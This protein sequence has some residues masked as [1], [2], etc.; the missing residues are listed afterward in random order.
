MTI[1]DWALNELNQYEIEEIKTFKFYQKFLEETNSS[2]QYPSYLRYLRKLKGK[3]LNNNSVKTLQESGI[4]ISRT[5]Q[6]P[7]Y[8]IVSS[9]SK[10][11]TLD[12]LLRFCKVDLTKYKVTRH[13]VNSWGKEGNENFQVK[14]WLTEINP[15]ELT[16]EQQA[17][18]FKERVKDFK[19]DYSKI[20]V[21]RSERGERM[22]EISLFDFHLGQLSWKAEVGIN[23]DI[24]IAKKMWMDATQ[25]FA[26]K[27]K[28][29]KVGE[30]LFPIGNDFF[31]V[32][33]IGN[34]TTAGTHQDEDGRV[35]KSF[36][37]GHELICDAI[38]LLLRTGAKIH[39]LIVPGNHDTQ[40]TFYLGEVIRTYYKDCKKVTVD[41]SPASRKYCVYGKNLI[42]FAHGKD[43]KIADLPNLFSLEAAKDW[44]LV[45]YREIHIGHYHHDRRMSSQ[46]V[47]DKSIRVRVMPS[48]VPP[49]S[50]SK[51]KGFI[52]VREAIGLLWKKEG[53]RELELYYSPKDYEN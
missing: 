27:V 23:Y 53:G 13:V 3:L 4:E 43:E 34:V 19:I 40:R 20:N 30:I 48:I 8:T 31:N 24:K 14:A 47:D 21:L 22:M 45:N 52:S 11:R 33:S 15:N 9:S 29:F 26:N 41:N 38:N 42:G 16:I 36:V 32:D 51:R 7:E 25:Y 46:V 37:D 2:T 10:I 6:G 44:S 35:Q 39:I 49:S 50:W 1:K 18:R 17:D 5:L 28:E 12:E